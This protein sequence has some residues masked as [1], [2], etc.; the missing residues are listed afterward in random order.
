MLPL[1]MKLLSFFHCGARLLPTAGW[2]PVPK[3]EHI[4]GHLLLVKASR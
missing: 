2:R 4:N 1:A 3:G